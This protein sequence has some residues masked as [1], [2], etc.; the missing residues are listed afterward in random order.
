[1]TQFT[2][3]YKK[4]MEKEQKDLEKME[5][6]KCKAKLMEYGAIT[7]K[8]KDGDVR[9]CARC[10]SEWLEANIPKYELPKLSERKE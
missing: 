10:Y 5:C 2:D 9:H 7:F 1:M 8:R 6:P 3:I 4:A